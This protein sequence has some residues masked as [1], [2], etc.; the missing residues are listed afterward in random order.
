MVAFSSG[1][2]AQGVALAARVLGV[3]ATIVMPAD[4]P[5]IKLKRTRDYGARVVTYDRYTES[6]EAIGAGHRAGD[7]ARSWSRP[8][9]IRTSSPVREPAGWSSP[10]GASPGRRVGATC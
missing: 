9:T 6:R 3:S 2:H 4:A 1:N 5:A 7:A 10:A 8:S